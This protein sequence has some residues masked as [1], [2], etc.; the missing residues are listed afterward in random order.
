M[1]S[2]SVLQKNHLSSK[3]HIIMGLI[4]PRSVKLSKP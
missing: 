3:L 4:N 1:G 2:Y